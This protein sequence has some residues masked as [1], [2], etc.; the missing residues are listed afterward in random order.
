MTKFRHCNDNSCLFPN[1][2]EK[3]GEV[4]AEALQVIRRLQTF[5]PRWM[6]REHVPG[7]GLALVLDGDICW[8]GAFGLASVETKRP[9]DA[10]TIFSAASLTKPVFA[11]LALAFHERGIIDL[12]RP[13]A[14]YLVHP[15]L[16]EHPLLPLMTGRHVLCHATGMPNWAGLEKDKQLKIKFTPG[17]G[18]GYSGEGFVYLQRVMEQVTGEA[19]EDLIQREVLRPLGMGESSFQWQDRFTQRYASTHDTTGRQMPEWH[20]THVNAAY[21]LLTTPA[22]YARFALYWMAPHLAPARAPVNRVSAH[23]AWSMGWG[24]QTTGQGEALFHWGDNG[25]YK[26]FVLA[27]PERRAAVVMMANGARGLR[28]AGPI[29]RTALGGSYPVFGEFLRPYYGRA[30]WRKHC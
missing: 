28:L 30:G 13:L 8:T 3:V 19:T 22:D 17:S 24:V 15:K 12:D 2:Y 20:P 11:T 18:F 4:V 16:A 9:V 1:V 26:N 7:C 10:D 21:S 27:F 25:G 14:E 23:V 5:V 6:E 29:L